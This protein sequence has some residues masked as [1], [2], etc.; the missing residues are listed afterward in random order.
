MLQVEG[1]AGNYNVGTPAVSGTGE[2][3]EGILLVKLRRG[4]EVRMRCI[5]VKGKALEHAKWSPCSAVGFEYDPW[6][7]LRHTD[8]WFEVGTKA[9]DEWPVSDNGNFE[10]RPAKDGSDVFDFAAKPSRFYFDVE[11][12][13]QLSPEVIVEKVSAFGLSPFSGSQLGSPGAVC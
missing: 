12:V 10:R 2:R 6:N 3:K 4:Q 7:K 11:A 5:A 9:E 13:G 1:G 8:L